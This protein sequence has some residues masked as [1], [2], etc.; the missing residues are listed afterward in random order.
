MCAFTETW[1]S[2]QTSPEILTELIPDGFKFLNQPR[3]G[4]KGGGL[5]IIYKK[6]LDL[7]IFE[8]RE[9]AFE[10]FECLNYTLYRKNKTLF[11]KI[12]YRS[13]PPP[14]LFPKQMFFVVLFL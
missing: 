6:H 2:N 4:K 13:P 8:S 9:L 1:L 12:V 11:M 10:N 14:P 5:G 7:D 3:N